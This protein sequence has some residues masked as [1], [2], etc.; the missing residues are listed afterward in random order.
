MVSDY[1][2]PMQLASKFISLDIIFMNIIL[3]ISG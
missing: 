3:K 1:N 2:N